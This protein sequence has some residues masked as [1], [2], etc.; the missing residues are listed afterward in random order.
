MEILG[1]AT[2]TGNKIFRVSVAKKHSDFYPNKFFE[3][4]YSAI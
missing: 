3:S 1:I 4:K 2:E